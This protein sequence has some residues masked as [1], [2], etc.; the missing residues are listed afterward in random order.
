M[1]SRRPNTANDA[2]PSRMPFAT[3]EALL[4]GPEMKKQHAHLLTE[5]RVLQKQH[6]GY[7]ARIQATEAV[8]GAAEAATGR[9]R[10]LEE[11]L[12]AIQAE[13]DAKTFEK[14]ASGEITRLS[15]FVDTNKSVWQKH[16]ELDTKVSH[17][18]DSL[19][20]FLRNTVGFEDA[21]RRIDI[22]EHDRR[23]DVHR[24]Q[25]L[26]REVHRL[27]SIRESDASCSVHSRTGLESGRDMREELM[28][29]QRLDAEV[30]GATSG[31]DNGILLPWMSPR[32]EV[33]VRQS[34]LTQET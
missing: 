34:P 23:E 18:S 14:W 21:L 11:Q 27:T 22:L 33:Q 5:M 20:R 1:A 25:S 3:A 2:S 19:D 30:S 12:A 15:I 17:I 29:N 26:E 4:W 13:D 31:T 32:E 28:M 24:I 7:D 9:I 8:A 16:A 10:H 6:Q